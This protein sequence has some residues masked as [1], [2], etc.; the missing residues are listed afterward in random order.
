[1][2]YSEKRKGEEW[3]GWIYLIFLLLT[4][5]FLNGVGENSA[6]GIANCSCNELTPIP[7]N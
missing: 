5:L 2:I 4:P 6:L 7:F 1:M 3:E